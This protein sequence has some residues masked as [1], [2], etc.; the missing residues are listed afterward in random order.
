[1]TKEE[2]EE[3][4]RRLL[5]A[6]WVLSE[7]ALALHAWRPDLDFG[8]VIAQVQPLAVRILPAG[9]EHEAALVAAQSV[10]EAEGLADPWSTATDYSIH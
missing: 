1:M 10:R 2:S 8:E 3:R 7:L 6:G 5:L 9:Y 4:T